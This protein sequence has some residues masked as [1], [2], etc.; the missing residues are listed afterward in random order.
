MLYAKENLQF[1]LLFINFSQTSDMR[2]VCQFQLQFSTKCK[3]KLSISFL[4][5]HRHK[6]IIILTNEQFTTAT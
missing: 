6:Y 4:I 1:T 2:C 5:L 3:C